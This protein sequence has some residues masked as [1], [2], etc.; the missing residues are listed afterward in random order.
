LLTLHHPHLLPTKA[1]GEHLGRQFEIVPFC[2]GGSLEKQLAVAE[3]LTLADAATLLAQLTAALSYLQGQGIQHRDIK[4]ANILL[5]QTNPLDT[6]MSDFGRSEESSATMLTMNRTTLL[7]S[8]PEAVNGMFSKASD[9][10][11][12][13]MV[14][15]ECVTGRHPLAH[16]PASQQHY[17]IAAG[18]IPIPETLPEQ[19]QFLLRGLLTCDHSQRWQGEQVSWW[20]LQTQNGALTASPSST[21]LMRSY[22]RSPL[23][24]VL[25]GL[26]V[27]V[28]ATR[29][30]GPIVEEFL[31]AIVALWIACLVTLLLKKALKRKWR[32]D[33]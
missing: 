22:C 6:V 2:A 28:I 26:P 9:W 31:G 23:T 13:G 5:R 16:L 24:I 33:S 7:Y 1:T 15:L 10:W 27:I 11:S 29:F 21:S 14:L 30:L 8:A 25:V 17:A 32:G 18:H 4:P 19:W 20:L 12:V 3:K